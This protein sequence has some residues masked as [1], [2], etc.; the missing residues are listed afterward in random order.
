MLGVQAAAPL[1]T[2]EAMLCN[3]QANRAARA[4]VVGPEMGMERMLDATSPVLVSS[5]FKFNPK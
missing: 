2:S 4:R 1:P 3:Q 5:D